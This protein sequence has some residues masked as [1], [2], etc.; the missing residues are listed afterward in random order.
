LNYF[1]EEVM[2]RPPKQSPIEQRRTQIE[3]ELEKLRL[4][5]NQKIRRDFKSDESFENWQKKQGEKFFELNEELI[6]LDNPAD[7][8]E[9]PLAVAATEI[10]VTL[11]EML[12]IISEGLIKTSFDGAYKAS[13][14]ISREELALAIGLGSEE[15]LRIINQDVDEIFADA[16][17]YLHNSNPE[18]A[19]KAYDRI[20]KHYS[21]IHPHAIA[22]EVGIHLFHRNYEEVRSSLNF[23]AR[24]REDSEL[25]EFLT[26]LKPIIKSLPL[27]DHLGEVIKEQIIAVTEGMKQDPFDDSYSSWR[28]TEY[29]SQMDENQRHAMLLSSVVLAAVQRYNFSKRLRRWE[30]YSS[31]PKDEEIERVIRNAIYTALEAE[32]TYYDSPSSKLF[33]DNYVELFPQRWTPAEHIVLLPKNKK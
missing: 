10:G 31:D 14:R 23:I 33:V 18:A 5:K 25:A 11:N 29:F 16:V 22:I 27:L 9:I 30:G 20:D 6:I 21:C 8:N 3:K 12:D 17:N 2:G 26:S 7:Y 32:S 1:R 24:R 13:A 15:L 19:Q 4:P 28:S